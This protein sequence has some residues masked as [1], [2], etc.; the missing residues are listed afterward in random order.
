MNWTRFHEL[1]CLSLSKSQAIKRIHALG[2]TE[3]E[4]ESENGDE[5]R[6]SRLWFKNPTTQ[7]SANISR[8]GNK[9]VVSQS[10]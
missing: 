4:V 2:F 7:D 6:G 9:W 5:G 8:F 3:F 10:S 1:Q